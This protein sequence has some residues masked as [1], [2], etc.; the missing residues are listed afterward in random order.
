M[1]WWKNRL[2]LAF[3]AILFTQAS[4]AQRV[5]EPEE[6]PSL[7]DRMY[8]G[9]NFGM[10]FGT[11]TFIDLSP[12]AGV[13]ITDKLSSGLGATYQYFNDSRFIGGSNSLFGGRVFSRFNIFP[14]V[15]LHAEYETLN[16]EVFNFSSDSFRRE[17]V[18]ALLV[19]GGYFMPFGNRGGVNFTFLYNLNFDIRRS[20]YNEPY[21]IRV[22]LV[23]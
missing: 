21:V 17:W 18:D 15:F 8:V 22:G 13:M 3:I 23:F 9:G 19:G 1:W 5:I 7:K 16:F 14:N 2:L 12:L 10:S 4:F 6:R 11:I 20:P